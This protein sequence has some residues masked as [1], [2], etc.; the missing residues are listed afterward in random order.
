[1]TEQGPLELPRR[2]FFSKFLFPTVGVCAVAA[3]FPPAYF[4]AEADK[5]DQQLLRN[6]LINPKLTVIEDFASQLAS[7]IDPSI[8]PDFWNSLS[9]LAELDTDIFDRKLRFSPNKDGGQYL[10]REQPQDP[11][12]DILLST[13]YTGQG[14]YKRLVS[15]LIAF[16]LEPDGRFHMADD[17]RRSHV[18]QPELLNLAQKVYLQRTPIDWQ[19]FDQAGKPMDPILGY[20]IEDGVLIGRSLST[21]LFGLIDI[22]D[23]N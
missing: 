13:E 23:P 5:T 8:D 11:H 15:G 9:S 18:S 20:S 7:W 3:L 14:E 16:G 10:F 4:I 2:G 17:G 6:R 21:D 19:T 12:G 1:M 22:G